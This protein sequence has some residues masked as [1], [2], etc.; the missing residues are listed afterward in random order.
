MT[1]GTMNRKTDINN[2][3]TLGGRTAIAMPVDTTVSAAP[4]SLNAV[5]SPP[6]QGR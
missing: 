2:P 5:P 1:M 6:P 3:A 4:N